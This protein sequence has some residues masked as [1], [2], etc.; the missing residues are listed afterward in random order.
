MNFPLFK[1]F[2]VSRLL[3][4]FLNRKFDENKNK[5]ESGIMKIVLML[6]MDT[7]ARIFL[8]GKTKNLKT[9]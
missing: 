1:S 4:S 2:R 8:G 6:K 7:K 5:L 9:L 3:T